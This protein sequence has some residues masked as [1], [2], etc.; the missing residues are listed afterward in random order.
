[1]DD[2]GAFCFCGGSGNGGREEVALWTGRVVEDGGAGGW[3][4]G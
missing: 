3:I 2:F 4:D 1:M